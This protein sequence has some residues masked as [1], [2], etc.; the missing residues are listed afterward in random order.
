[1]TEDIERKVNVWFIDSLISSSSWHLI[2]DMSNLY[3]T[4]CIIKSGICTRLKLEWS[5]RINQVLT[6]GNH[7]KMTRLGWQRVIQMHTQMCRLHI[8]EAVVRCLSASSCWAE[9]SWNRT[10]TVAQTTSPRPTMRMWKEEFQHG[11]TF[12]LV[13]GQLS[14]QPTHELLWESCLHLRDD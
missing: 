7:Q 3:V 1:M 9:S 4:A 8:Q 14:P 2:G 10:K 5:D 12:P 6:Q 11:N 13:G